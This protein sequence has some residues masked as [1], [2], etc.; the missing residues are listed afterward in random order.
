MQRLYALDVSF[1]LISLQA[2]M[3]SRRTSVRST[4]PPKFHSVISCLTHSSAV[5]EQVD[6]P[7]V[8]PHGTLRALSRQ[9]AYCPVILN[10]GV[11]NVIVPRHH[12]SNRLVITRRCNSNIRWLSILSGVYNTSST[13]MFV[14]C[15]PPVLGDSLSV[16][17][18]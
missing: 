4:A 3:P 13:R 7:F 18:I 10:A 9:N 12:Y 1:T 5:Q 15:I 6:I 2:S 17:Y 16:P 14:L 8:P 11:S